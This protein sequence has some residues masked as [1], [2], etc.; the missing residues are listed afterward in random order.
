MIKNE[1]KFSEKG[2]GFFRTANDYVCNYSRVMYC[3]YIIDVFCE[4]RQEIEASYFSQRS[5]GTA[6][7]HD[8]SEVSSN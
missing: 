1:Q 6:R 3:T 2:G 5:I 4:K 7:W 8:F